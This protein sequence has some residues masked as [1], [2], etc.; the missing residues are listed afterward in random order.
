MSTNVT[1]ID[2]FALQPAYTEQGL[3]QV[4]GTPSDATKKLQTQLGK[5]VGTVSQP[6]G[7]PPTPTIP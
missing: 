3:G 7:R 5:M 2:I 6:S 1:V 4:S